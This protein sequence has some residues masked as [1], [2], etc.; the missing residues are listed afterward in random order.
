MK[1]RPSFVRLF[2]SILLT[3]V[4]VLGGQHLLRAAESLSDLATV[5]DQRVTATVSG[6]LSLLESVLSPDL[7][8]AHSNGKV[9]SKDSFLNGLREGSL[10][11]HSFHYETREFRSASPDVVLMTGRARIE[12]GQPAHAFQ[13]SFLATWRLEAGKWRFL[14][15]QSCRLPTAP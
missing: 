13:L 1:Y 4:L 2:C 3:L 10:K 15:W 11:Y 9:D 8:Y 5:D 7:F 14:A 12:A 6:N